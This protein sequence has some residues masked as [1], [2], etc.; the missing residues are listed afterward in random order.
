MK[1]KCDTAKREGNI[2]NKKR[3]NIPDDE[4]H[5]KI[6]TDPFGSWTG[7][8]EDNEYEKPIQ[9]VDDL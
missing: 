9:D 4:N 1:N 7:V 8:C 2:N 5:S 3:G 6:I